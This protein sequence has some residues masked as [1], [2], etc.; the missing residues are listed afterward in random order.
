LEKL[1]AGDFDALILASSGL[2][3]LGL[4]DRIRH[5]VSM[6]IM[7]PA[8]GQGA[9]G[10]EIRINDHKTRELVQCL[11]DHDSYQC[12]TAER[13][14]NKRLNGG[15][16]APIAA[17]AV[18]QDD[19]ISISGLVGYPDGSEIIKTGISGPADK[20][21]ELGDELGRMLLSMG[22]DRMLEAFRALQDGR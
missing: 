1:D 20:Y 4:G 19:I 17:H 7:L 5:E 8:I 13:M 16:Y 10:L 11:N 14:V 15:C 21:E 2:K 22:A 18:K 9:L 12:V 3:R 6:E